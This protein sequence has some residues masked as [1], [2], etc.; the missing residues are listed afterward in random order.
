[1]PEY[2][3]SNAGKSYP[4]AAV[5]VTVTAA[6]SFGAG[7]W[8]QVSAATPQAELLY[9]VT[10]HWAAFTGSFEFEIDVG[11]GPSSSEVVIATFRGV[12]RSGSQIVASNS[13]IRAL[14]PIASIPNGS[15]IAVRARRSTGS[16][17]DVVVGVQ[18]LPVAFVGGT[19]TTTTNPLLSL[20]SAA[21]GASITPSGS[22]W[23]NSNWAQI[24]A[25]AASALYL[26]HLA[27]IPNPV[28]GIQ[29]EL[30][31][32]IGGAGSEVVITTLKAGFQQGSEGAPSVW[33]LPHL[34]DAIPASSRVAVRLRKKGTDL[35]AWTVG[36]GAYAKPL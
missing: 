6:A 12:Q 23:G 36:I 15:R 32:G 10:C 28:S 11:V 22:A 19:V 17:R 27:V 35:T 21:A 29:A 13:L 9:G 7:V 3:T 14:I 1:M 8:V 16:T 34:L 18:T 4:P 2:L 30:D 5:G 31:I 33:R 20:P 24:L 25:S 26:N